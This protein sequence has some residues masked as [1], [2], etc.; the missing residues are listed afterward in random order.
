MAVSGEHIQ[1]HI[2]PVIGPQ[3]GLSLGAD[4]LQHNPLRRHT[5]LGETPGQPF[6][7]PPV[8]ASSY[9]QQLVR[10]PSMKT[11]VSAA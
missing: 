9:Q 6:C 5:P 10:V 1:S 7:R 3:V 11:T 2:A 4:P 8:Q